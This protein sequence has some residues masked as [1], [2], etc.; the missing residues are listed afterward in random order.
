[1]S[2]TWE[3]GV[4]TVPKRIA[5]GTLQRTLESLCRGGFDNP[6]LFIDGLPNSE[7]GEFSKLRIT[8][9]SEALRIY[10]NFHLGISELFI[11]NPHAD[12]YAMFQD[13]FVTYDNLREYLESCEYPEKGYLNLYTFPENLKPTKGWY[14]SNQLGKGAVALVFDNAA[15]RALIT[16]TFWIN[17]P[18]I[19]HKDPKRSWKFVDGGI[20]EALK[21]QGFKEYVHNPSLV[22]HTGLVSTLGNARH[23]LANSFMGEGFDVV[24]LTKPKAQQEARKSRIGLVGLPTDKNLSIALNA[25]VYRWLVKP[26]PTEGLSKVPEEVDVMVCPLG[27]KLEKFLG[28][29]DLVL[30]V[31]KPCYEDMLNRCKAKQIVNIA[32]TFELPTT[33][34][35]W[36]EFNKSVRNN[37]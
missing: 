10:G 19:N 2:I 36:Q 12:R 16:S 11:R 32:P 31:D 5:N 20:V 30:Y 15:L 26:H 6:R 33:E 17:R 22:Q 21:Q 35:G 29:V 37:V 27:H 8:C 13:D 34:E 1:V 3:Y 23:A 18:A 24:S 9:H 28:E 14:L 25:D 7:L 4:T